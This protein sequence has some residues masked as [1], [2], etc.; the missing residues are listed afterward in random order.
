LGS[1]K[2]LVIDT[3][4]PTVTGVSS[5]LANGTYT[6]GQVVPVTVSFNEPVTVTGTPQLTLS[7]GFPVSTAVNYT[8]GSG[9]STLTFSYTVAANNFSSDLDYASTTALALNGGTIQDAATN[10]A[11]LTLVA[12]GAAGSLG[13]NKNLVISDTTA[14]SVVDVVLANGGGTDGRAD[15][16]DTVTV[17]F[18]EPIRASTVCSAWSTPGDKALSGNGQVTVTITNNGTNDTLSV[19]ATTAACPTGLIVGSVALGGDYVTADATFSGNGSNASEVG[20]TASGVL[21]VTLGSGSPSVPVAVAQA[22]VPIYT[23]PSGLTDLAA[24]T[25]GTAP[26]NGT[27]SRF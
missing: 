12:P 7:T 22:A 2:N 16:D 15:K 17:T 8:S 19:A 1:N 3:A 24:N 9:T 10:N 14:P 21:T 26:V 25:L 18:S 20:L 4:S 5:T 6:T 11:T 23:P 13:A 27:S